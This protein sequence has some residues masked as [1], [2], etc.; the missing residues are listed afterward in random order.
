MRFEQGV[1]LLGKLK[2]LGIDNIVLGGGEP[3]AWPHNTVALATTAKSEGFFV[4]VGTNGIAMPE[5]YPSLACF[6]RYVL[7]LDSVD[8][9]VH[10]ALRH[11]G[12]GHHALI[13]ERLNALMSARK[14]V[15][16]STV[17]TSQNVRG[18]PELANLLADYQKRGGQLHGWHLYKFIPEG[19][20]GRDNASWLDIPSQRY[21]QAC[22]DMKC[23]ALGFTVFKRK[24]MLHSKTVDFFWFEGGMLRSNPRS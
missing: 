10:N 7:P 3:F 16:V 12:P 8:A 21:D 20:G 5:S 4:Q 13:L 1:E 6:D 11:H 17:V 19:R 2:Q 23:R 14:S 9:F 18:L 24:D 15:T 22:A